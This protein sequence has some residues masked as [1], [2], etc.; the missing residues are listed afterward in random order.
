MS[1]PED[2]SYYPEEIEMPIEEDLIIKK[3]LMLLMANEFHQENFQRCELCGYI[4]I[5]TEKTTFIEN[6]YCTNCKISLGSKLTRMEKGYKKS[7]P[8]NLKD[9]LFS[10]R[11]SFTGTISYG[12]WKRRRVE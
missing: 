2:W 8:I 7:C 3:D 9:H 11:N 12:E 6:C 1:W 5:P 4:F 10:R